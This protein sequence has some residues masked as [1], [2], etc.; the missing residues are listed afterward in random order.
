M[1]IIGCQERTR[2]GME[3]GEKE[4]TQSRSGYAMRRSAKS[5]QVKAANGKIFHKS[6][7]VTKAKKTGAHSKEELEHLINRA[8][9]SGVADF[10]AKCDDRFKFTM[11]VL[12][13]FVM[14]LFV[15]LNFA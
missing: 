5:D 2:T 8:R 9:N 10:L 3:S 14:G 12:V 1:T 15:L 4:E 6:E 7:E 13:F 11:V